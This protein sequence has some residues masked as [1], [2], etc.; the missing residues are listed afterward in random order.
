MAECPLNCRAGSALQS[1]HCYWWWARPSFGWGA[2][3]AARSQTTGRWSVLMGLQQATA[4]AQML[5]SLR[6]RC[7]RMGA[8][9]ACQ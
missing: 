9:A 4:R 2:I 1:Q 5:S 3:S 6:R 8:I 7:C